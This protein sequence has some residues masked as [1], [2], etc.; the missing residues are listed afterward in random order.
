MDEQ[1]RQAF[2]EAVERKEKAAQ[3][4]KP[5][6]QHAPQTIEAHPTDNH[7]EQSIRDMTKGR[8]NRSRG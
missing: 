3:S 1:Q 7:G 6:H 8:D 4:V 5:P 2:K